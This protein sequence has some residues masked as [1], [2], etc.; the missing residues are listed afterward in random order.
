[1]NRRIYLDANASTF[2]DPRVFQVLIQQLQEEEGNPSSI[3]AH[4]RQSRRK[5]EES[6]LIIAKFLK[7]KPNEIIFTSGGTEGAYLLLHGLLKRFA[8]GHLITSNVE[9]PCV[10]ETVKNFENAGYQATYLSTGLHGAVHPDQVKDALRPDTRLIT[11]MA[12]NNE[13]GVK[14]D[15]QAIAEIALEAQVP[16]IVDGVAL[17]GKEPFQI[18]R[19]ISAMFFSGHKIHAPKGIGFCFCRQSL[20]LLPLFSGG[21]QEFHRRA[22]T[23]N[24][25]GIAA[26]AEAVHILDKEQILITDQ[27][28]ERRD[29]LEKMLINQL[30]GISVNG[31]GPRI[32]NTVN[33][34]FEGVDG[35]SLLLNLDLEVISASHGSACSSGALEPSRV[36]MNMGIPS[37]QAR[38]AIR[39]S[40]GRN[41]TQ[42]EIFEAAEIIKKIVKRL[43]GLSR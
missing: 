10:Y 39:F 42:E 15:L 32:V 43:R 9:H 21:N 13:T 40:V 30:D 7:V 6:R 35:E 34:S 36:I 31:E 18:P 19:G 29:E 12:A 20:K 28:R 23:E 3:H 24:L 41:T 2:L 4:G 33:L 22:G 17:L 8:N 38:S 16:F 26:L 25:P 1:M 5:L 37:K 14:T 27:L 11:L